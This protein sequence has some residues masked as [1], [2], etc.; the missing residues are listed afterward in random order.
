MNLV[1]V[2]SCAQRTESMS[3]I[4]MLV[5]DSRKKDKQTYIYIVL[6]N[7]KTFGN[8]SDVG[9]C[10]LWS[11]LDLCFQFLFQ[12]QSFCVSTNTETEKE[13]KKT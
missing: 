13:K 11:Q 12:K 4:E 1:L 2:D 7:S 8:Y 10:N 5:I 6:F 3:Y 9:F